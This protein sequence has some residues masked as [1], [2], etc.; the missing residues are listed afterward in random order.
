M[1]SN[2]DICSYLLRML[3]FFHE[4]LIVLPTDAFWIASDRLDVGFQRPLK[5]LVHLLVVI[6]IMSD[7]KHTVDIVPDG[8]AE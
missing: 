5:K 8:T 1:G 4:R 3:K 2:Y 6:V 7:A